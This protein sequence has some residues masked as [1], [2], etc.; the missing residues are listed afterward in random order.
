[1]SL[2]PSTCDLDL[3]TVLRYINL[4]EQIPNSIGPFT[5]EALKT[6]NNVFLIKIHLSKSILKPSSLEVK[7]SYLKGV[8]VIPKMLLPDPSLEGLAESAPAVQTTISVVL[9][10]S[11]VGTLALGA[12]SSL[13]SII[14]FQQFVGYFIYINIEYPQQVEIFFEMLQASFWDYLPNPTA[15]L[16]ES[17][18]Q[19]VLGSSLNADLDPPRKF[20]KYEMTSFFIENGSTILLTN[21]SFLLLLLLVLSLKKSEKLANNRILKTIKVY[22]KWNV[23]ARTFLENGIPLSLAIFLQLRVLSSEGAYLMICTFMTLIS[24]IYF[25]IF[26]IFLF[27]ILSKRNNKHLR[28][29]LIK[30]IYG[31]LYEGVVL[32]NSGKYYHLIILLRGV[33]LTFLV[34]ILD[35]Y[36]L[37]QI[38]SLI[39]V[40]AGFVFYLF[41]EVVMEDSKLNIIVRVKEVFIFIGQIGILLLGL[42]S[43]SES[44]YKIVGWII[45]GFLCSALLIELGYM[46]LLQ[47]LGIKEIYRKILSILRSICSPGSNQSRKTKK[48]NLRKIHIE[49]KKIDES[50]VSTDKSMV[51]HET[52]TL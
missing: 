49:N 2:T 16:T 46:V 10:G 11:L 51:K 4:T 37:L 42:E 19:K 36:P 5:Y 47:I 30:K 6:D 22:L 25:F 13:W 24:S 20:V 21:I 35:N 33:F 9:G 44:Y 23:I 34:T 50:V 41:K 45:V 17:L 26:T 14:S 48:I 52:S 43:T 32:N 29:A 3:A 1:M 7:L 40:N 12:T 28:F 27:Q 15:S 31:T 18:Y 8:L 39:F 38:V